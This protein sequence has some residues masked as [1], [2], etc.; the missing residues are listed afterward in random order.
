MEG[1]KASKVVCGGGHT[2]I[3]TDQGDLYLMGRGRDGQLGR[4]SEVESTAA[5]RAE[6][7]LVEYFR[8]NNL[9]VVNLALGSNHSLAV[10]SPR[11]G[12]K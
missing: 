3:V 1:Q 4:G 8:Q 11:V 10:A 9:K 12:K 5:Y 2:G 7:N 6:P